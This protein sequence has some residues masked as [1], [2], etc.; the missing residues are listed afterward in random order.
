MVARESDNSDDENGKE[1]SP[2]E[3]ELK[4]E[5]YEFQAELAILNSKMAGMEE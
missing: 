3:P 4:E 5:S 2:I 1:E